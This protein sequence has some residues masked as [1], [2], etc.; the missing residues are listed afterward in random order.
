MC[1][2]HEGNIK[3]IFDKYELNEKAN[4]KINAIQTK[5]KQKKLTDEGKDCKEAIVRKLFYQSNLLLNSNF[6]MYVWQLFKSFIV[7]FEEK[8]P[9]IHRLDKILVENFRAF[10]SCFMKFEVINDTPHNELNLINVA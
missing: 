10:F 2:K 6:L 4:A 3:T 8:E 9:L 7:S 5:M 1:E